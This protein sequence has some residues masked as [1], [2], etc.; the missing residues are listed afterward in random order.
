M[1]IKLSPSSTFLVSQGVIL[2]GLGLYFV[3]IR[4]ALLPEDPRFMGTTLVEIQATVPGLLIWLR[5]VFSVMGGFMFTAG[6]L[7]TYI[8][9][10]A[11]QQLA[12]GARSVVALAGL[13][14]IGWM[15]VVNFMI[16]S[17]FK[18][19]LLTFNLPW[20]VALVF[21]WRESRQA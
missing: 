2:M 17:D 21:S 18:W 8:A 7:T 20:I 13:T 19:L 11:F 5:R 9:V 4:P 14:S 6:L 1:K 10:T 15:A 16:N 3:F 12:R